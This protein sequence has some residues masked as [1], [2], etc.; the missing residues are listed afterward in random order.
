MRTMRRISL[1]LLIALALSTPAFAQGQDRPLSLN[2]IIGPSFGTVGTTFSGVGSVEFKIGNHISLVG[3]GG[4]LQRAPFREAAAIAA[5]TTF[6]NAERMHVNAYHWNGNVKV[7]FT[8]ASVTPYVTA[9]AGS[10]SADTVTPSRQV[11]G[12]WIEDRRG[13]TDFATNVGAGAMYRVNEW[14]GVGADY[15]TFFVHRDRETPRVHRF[16]TGLTFSLK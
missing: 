5:P 2:G 9:G 1:A 8:F 14:L 10:F 11:N 16:T 7:P 12:V 4:M 6:D 15:R 13:V 3:E